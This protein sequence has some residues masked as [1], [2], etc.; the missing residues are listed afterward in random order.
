MKRNAYY[1]TILIILL[2]SIFLFAQEEV[3]TGQD[4]EEMLSAKETTAS[5]VKG[6]SIKKLHDEID[7]NLKE[8]FNCKEVSLNLWVVPF[9]GEGKDE[10]DVSVILDTDWLIVSTYIISITEKTRIEGLKY[11]LELNYTMDQSKLALDS[12]G[13]LY[14]LYEIPTKYYDK[15]ELIDY[16]NN[17]A[18]FVSDNY[19]TIRKFIGI[20]K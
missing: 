11:L 6:V 16:I 15:N 14:L 7:K 19:N 9:F 8:K 5:S 1:L 13:D 2:T 10:I 12:N 4:S 20:K 17:S 3:I 18:L